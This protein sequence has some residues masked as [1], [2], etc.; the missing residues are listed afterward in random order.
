MKRLLLIPV[1]AVLLDLFLG[2]E[3]PG[4][5]WLEHGVFRGTQA[6]FDALV[7]DDVR[8]SPVLWLLVALGPVAWGLRA[9]TSIP[10]T[11][12][13]RG[14]QLAFLG[15]LAAVA[16]AL[17][18]SRAGLGLAGLGVLAVLAGMGSKEARRLPRALVIAACAALAMVA[19]YRLLLGHHGGLLPG[20]RTVPYPQGHGAPD[21]DA[22]ATA[23]SFA[24]GLVFLLGTGAWL[25]SRPDRGAWL[26]LL[27][28][29]GLGA[30]L[31]FLARGEGTLGELIVLLSLLPTMGVAARAGWLRGDSLPWAAAS[32]TS[33]ALLWGLGCFAHAEV[34]GAW[35][36]PDPAAQAASGLTRLG[37][38]PKTFRTVRAPNDELLLVHRRDGFVSRWST[39][40]RSVLDPGA[41][42][43]E[44]GV[45]GLRFDGAPEELVAAPEIGRWFGTLDP[46]GALRE[47]LG[48]DVSGAIWSAPF[49]GAVDQIHAIRGCWTNALAWDAPRSRLLITCENMPRVVL[50]DP[51]TESVDD[52]VAVPGSGDIVD[53]RWDGSAWWAASLWFSP[54]ITRLDA[55][56]LAPLERRFVGG[57]AY[58][59]APVAGRQLVSRFYGSR[60]SV[61]GERRSS[62]RT[63]L[64][65]RALAVDEG[66]DLV[67][68]SSQFDGRLRI[69]DL[70]SGERLA[71]LPVGGDVKDIAYDPLL[72]RAWFAGLCGLFEL[73][74][75]R[76]ARSVRQR[77]AR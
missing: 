35:A 3:L 64:G 2:V 20:L 15:A 43:G 71:S 9:R 11:A 32:G 26:R 42:A 41:A 36:C 56:T 40:G 72:G 61:L 63:G 53:L 39:A 8:R 69:F 48:E 47:Q 60:V 21:P 67:L 50:W 49:G 55:E 31:W 76:F 28:A 54:Y 4:V 52:S 75:A 33:L 24:A 74:A 37:D 6:L 59:V 18:L 70:D 38:A 34:Y 25:R 57:G 45:A 73:D 7:T 30:M 1:A 62:L 27:A 68:V 51:A 5:L 10:W 12:W 16:L 19:L 29:G 46:H 23:F 17:L 58:R 65:T 44:P 22:L 77:E 66:R 13:L 14:V